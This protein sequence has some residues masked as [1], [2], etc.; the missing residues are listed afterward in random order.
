MRDW[1]ANQIH[2]K[3]GVV[4][5]GMRP[6]TSGQQAGRVSRCIGELHMMEE[7]DKTRIRVTSPSRT[8]AGR[9]KHWHL[10]LTCSQSRRVVSPLPGIRTHEDRDIMTNKDK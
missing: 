8:V 9:Q 7:G 1:C 3:C 4:R 6:R 5:P 2:R 10:Q